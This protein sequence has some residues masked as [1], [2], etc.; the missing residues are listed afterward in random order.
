MPNDG[1]GANVGTL[2]GAA[3]GPEVPVRTPSG[4][5]SRYGAASQGHAG[6]KATVSGGSYRPDVPDRTFPR[7]AIGAR[8]EL[9]ARHDG[10]T[11][12]EVGADIIVIGSHGRTGL[13]RLLM[14]SVAE[15]V[16]R[17]AGCPVLTVKS[18]PS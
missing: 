15:H 6:E 17:K 1:V 11:Q 12:A 2:V 14:G 8:V 16:V 3:H 5:G 18:P 7:V 9:D 10:R 13:S 4:A